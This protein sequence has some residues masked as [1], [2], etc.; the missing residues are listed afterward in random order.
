MTLRPYTKDDARDL[1][2]SL[3][4]EPDG[5][6]ERSY[7]KLYELMTEYGIAT[8]IQRQV[9]TVDDRFY[10]STDDNDNEHDPFNDYI[11]LACICDD[12]INDIC[13]TCQIHGTEIP[14]EYLHGD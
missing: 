6:S 7:E 9:C 11:D 2:Y 8:E 1:A 10:I 3:L 12:P 5:I 4:H 13:D 14:D